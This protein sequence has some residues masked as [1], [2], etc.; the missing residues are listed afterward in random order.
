MNIKI[1]NVETDKV[2]KTK[3]PGVI[4]NENL[5]W[6]DHIALVKTKVRML[7]SSTKL[8]IT[9]QETLCNYYIIP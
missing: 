9:Y 1:D 8:E 6:E 4:I 5:T 3:F 2:S 7:V